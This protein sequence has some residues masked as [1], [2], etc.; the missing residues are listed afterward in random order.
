[1]KFIFLSGGLIGFLIA[2]VSGL[3]AGRAFDNVL[4]DAALGCLAGALL[5]QWLWS[6]FLRG[7]RETYLA[8]HHPPVPTPAPAAALTPLPAKPTKT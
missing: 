8:R 7:F 1:M 4:L 2:G 6:I 5:F 3:M